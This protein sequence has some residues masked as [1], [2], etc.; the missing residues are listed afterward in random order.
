LIRIYEYNTLVSAGKETVNK[1]GIE[2]A[3]VYNR[4]PPAIELK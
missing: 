4:G 2:G 1:N 3:E